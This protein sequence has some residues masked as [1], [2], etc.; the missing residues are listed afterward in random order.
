[1]EIGV[2]QW[3]RVTG[4]GWQGDKV[5]V[6]R[7]MFSQ[8]LYFYVLIPPSFSWDSFSAC[9]LLG[10]Q[11]VKTFL[12]QMVSY[13]LGHLTLNVGKLQSILVLF[14]SKSLLLLVSFYQFVSSLA[15]QYASQ[16]AKHKCCGRNVHKIKAHGWRPADGQVAWHP[17]SYLIWTWSICFLPQLEHMTGW[18][19]WE[20]NL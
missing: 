4:V 14:V 5:L 16:S 3:E 7:Q 17:V 13:C 19:R 10:M 11:D 2:W 15:P 18:G 20:H 6:Q 1:M 8:L 9:S 12:Q